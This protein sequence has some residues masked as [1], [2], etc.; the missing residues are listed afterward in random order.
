MLAVE[1]NQFDFLGRV[2][3]NCKAVHV[4]VLPLFQPYEGFLLNHG[5]VTTEDGDAGNINFVIVAWPKLLGDVGERIEDDLAT[6]QESF[7]VSIPALDLQVDPSDKARQTTTETP[8]NITFTSR[9]TVSGNNESITI[10]RVVPK[11]TE[12]KDLLDDGQV[13]FGVRKVSSEIGAIEPSTRN[14]RITAY[15]IRATHTPF[16]L[17]RLTLFGIRTFRAS[18]SGSLFTRLGI[19]GIPFLFPLLYQVGLGFTPIQSGLLMV[20]QAMAA[21]SLKITMPAILRHFGYRLVLISNTLLIGL[22]IL[23]FATIGVGTPVWLIVI[24]LFAYGFF[25][26]LQ[27]TSMN[28]LAYSDI[29]EEQASNASTIASTTQQMAI[30]FGVA[31]SSIAVAFFVPDKSH[32]TSA[33]IIHGIHDAFLALGG[34][35]ILSTF[36]FRELRSDDGDTVSQH[37]VVAQI[38]DS[39][40]SIQPNAH[41]S[42]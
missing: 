28:T 17:L 21:M 31:V 6:G 35:T 8:V 10:K 1:S 12:P 37:K 9:H 33:E 13:L 20:P 11:S 7:D 16:P 36:I 32:T 27:Y 2:T 42:G 3:K 15:C 14:Q 23:L 26:S 19:G 29:N 40:T 41:R 22:Q 30:S 5:E 4:L 34:W 25:T 39:V 18:V 38:G 24:Q